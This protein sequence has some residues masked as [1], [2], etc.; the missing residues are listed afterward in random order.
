MERPTRGRCQVRAGGPAAFAFRFGAP[1][2]SLSQ[3]RDTARPTAV[4]DRCS[5]LFGLLE[6][7][8][9]RV[10]RA[11]SDRKQR[12]VPRPERTYG[13]IA[14]LQHHRRA[15]R[16]RRFRAGAA[17]GAA[18]RGCDP[19]RTAGGGPWRMLVDT[20][21]DAGMAPGFH[22]RRRVGLPS[23][24]A[25]ERLGLGI[26]VGETA[27]RVARGGHLQQRRQSDDCARGVPLGLEGR[28]ARAIAADVRGASERT[29][30]IHQAG[31]RLATARR[32]VLKS[33][34]SPS[35]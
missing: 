15:C 19:P 30:N 17:Q 8:A 1:R 22:P 34:Q 6:S 31:R 13:A 21:S 9:L 29:S 12:P 16:Q 32:R 24:F 28:A 2:R 4:T 23:P 7:Q 27:I 18:G 10:R 14:I 35:K 11:T 26:H 3:R 5:R 20:R 33:V 25:R